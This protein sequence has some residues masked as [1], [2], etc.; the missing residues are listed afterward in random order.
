MERFG[1]KTCETTDPHL[2]SIYVCHST[3]S[4]VQQQQIITIARKQSDLLGYLPQWPWDDF[5]SQYR[6]AGK[7]K[8][9]C[10]PNMSESIQRGTQVS[11]PETDAG[12]WSNSKFFPRLSEKLNSHNCSYNKIPKNISFVTERDFVPFRNTNRNEQ[13]LKYQSETIAG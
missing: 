12:R 9:S 7:M 6:V 1:P 11:W 13:A 4:V 5:I 8:W 3:S 2:S 10:L